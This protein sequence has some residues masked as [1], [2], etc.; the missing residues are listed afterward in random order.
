M[1]V[2][3]DGDDF[4][5]DGVMYKGTEGL[6]KLLTLKNPG[7]V[8]SED[9]NTYKDMLLQTKAFLIEGQE[10]RVKCNRGDKYKSIIKPIADEWKGTPYSTPCAT[11][12]P[13]QRKRIRRE[14]VTGTGVVFIPSDPNDLVHRHRILFGAHQAGNTSLYNE[15]QAVNDKLLAL[16]VFDLELIQKLN[17]RINGKYKHQ[18]Y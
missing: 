18:P 7:D 6:W 2:R 1:D 13:G 3:I 5:I 17:A 4:T 12:N 9:L 15:L 14:S 11:P 16:G 10:R 8:S